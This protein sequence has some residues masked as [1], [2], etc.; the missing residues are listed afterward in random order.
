MNPLELVLRLLA[1]HTGKGGADPDTLFIDHGLGS[2]DAVALAAALTAATGVPLPNT[3]LYDHPTPRALAAYLSEGERERRP[4]PDGGGGGARPEPVAIVGIGCRLPGAAPGPAGLWDLLVAGTD[5]V[6]PVPAA[7]AGG[8]TGW[9][10]PGVGVGGFLPDVEA[11]DPAF[12]SLNAREA[13]AMDP[14]Q[15]LLLEVAHEALQDA[16]LRQADLAGS[17]TGVYVG[18]SG[19][20]HIAAAFPAG[21]RPDGYTPTGA[22][23]SI[24]ANRVSYVFDLHGPSMAIDT[25]CSS[26][27]VAIHQAVLALRTGQCDL[28]LAGGVNAVLSPEVGRCFGAAGVLAPDGRCKSFGA[29]AD[30][31]GRSE[32]AVVLALRPL[33]DALAAGDR[34]YALILGGAVNSDGRT[35]GLMSPSAPAQARLLRAACRAAG[36]EPGDVEYVEAHGSGTR[37]GDLMELRA[38]AEVMGGPGRAEPLRVGSVK[39]NLGHLEAAAGAAGLAKAALALH[40]GVLPGSLH[41]DPPAADF[42][43]DSAPVRV[44]TKPKPWAGRLAGVSSFGFGG[45]N[46]HLVLQAPPPGRSPGRAPARHHLPLSAH[47][48]AGLRELAAR[49]RDLLAGPGP[50][51]AAACHTAAARRDHHAYRLAVSGADAAELSAALD[52]ALTALV[53]DPPVPVRGPGTAALVFTGGDARLADALRRAGLRPALVLGDAR[54]EPAAAGYSGALTAADAR[55][56]ASRRDDLLAALASGSPAPL[57]GVRVRMAGRLAQALCRRLGPELAV[58]VV[59]GPRSCVISGPEA[60][61]ERVRDAL[62]RAGVA[63]AE[64]GA[65]DVVHSAPAAA[66]AGRL[67]AELA[68]LAPRAGRVP[69]VST[70]TGGPVE[71]PELG[72][73]HWAAQLARPCLLGDALAYAL[74][75]GVRTFVEIGPGVLPARLRALDGAGEARAVRCAGSAD[76]PGALL[77]LYELGHDPDWS[78][79]NPAAGVTS[80]PLLPWSRD[81][82]PLEATA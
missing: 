2:H 46:A 64:L 78:V 72:P 27:L 48:P 44:V 60:A 13:A 63:C 22:A 67:E 19:T 56:A 37:L 39:S 82:S 77:R 35:N 36:V 49:W 3:V 53:A 17:Q 76:L 41:A 65:V 66:L 6:G 43:W 54:G 55:A 59:E 51:L 34:V 47:T 52:R 70:V 42:P 68:G 10:E 58:S 16:G 29:D 15:R 30:G 20:D 57:A 79:L 81:W 21:A 23:H 31:M 74:S 5:A 71:G 7:R 45:T 61:L 11:F 69:L 75:Q 24:A 73:A 62:S 50:D 1:E 9:A 33:P 14:Q 8:N 32:G 18:I 12:F 4:A 28:A 40:H 25:A 38:L 26:S 80:V